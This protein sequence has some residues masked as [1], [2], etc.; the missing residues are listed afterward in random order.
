[1]PNRQLREGIVDSRRVSGLSDFAYRIFTLLIAVVDDAGRTYGAA[2]LLTPKL[3]PLK[4][5]RMND[6]EKALVE[7]RQAGLATFYD[8]DGESYLQLCRWRKQGSAEISKF[9]WMDG[10]F[11]IEYVNRPTRDGVKSFVSTSIVEETRPPADPLPTPSAPGNEGEESGSN[12][13]TVTNTITNTNTNNSFVEEAVDAW[14]SVASN[15]Q[16]LI[17]VRK[18][19]QTKRSK[20]LTR[21]KEQDW[22]DDFK[23]ACEKLPLGGDGWQP[24]FEWMVKNDD[25]AAKVA[26]GYYE[27]RNQSSVNSPR[28]APTSSK[29]YKAD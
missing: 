14:N 12:A 27:F 18:L 17:S 19:S 21:L 1:M 26:N 16:S 4:N 29:R 13:I 24:D 2:D 6:V 5:R 28:Q 7:I 25:H 11:E 23:L 9:P 10:S 20:L 15:H 8:V 3:L 22:L